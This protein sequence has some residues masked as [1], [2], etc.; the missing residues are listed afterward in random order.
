MFDKRRLDMAIE[1]CDAYIKATKE[2]QKALK[3]VS[4]VELNKQLRTLG[5]KDNAKS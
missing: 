5:R 1:K 4:F 3:K 2:L